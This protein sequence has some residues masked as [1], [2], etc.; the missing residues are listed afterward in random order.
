MSKVTQLRRS[1]TRGE[2]LS[3]GGIA[4]TVLALHVIGWFTLAAIVAPHHYPWAAA[5]SS[6]SASG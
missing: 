3:L 1:L 6:A 2:W 5:R 4:F